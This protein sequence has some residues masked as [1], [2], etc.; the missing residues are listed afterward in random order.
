M[1]RHHHTFFR[2]FGFVIHPAKSVLRP[3]YTVTYLGFKV[4]EMTV[5]LMQERK[6]RILVPVIYLLHKD[7]STVRQLVECVDKEV[8]SF[9]GVE[10]RALWH[11]SM[12]NDKIRA[13]FR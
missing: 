6:D 3:T 5:S 8:A 13:F 12:E 7:M 1:V 2:R 11:K 9:Q 4:R 10:Y